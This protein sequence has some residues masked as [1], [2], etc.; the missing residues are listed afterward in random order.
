MY[1]VLL[2]AG[3]RTSVLELAV[4]VAT[5]AGRTVVV[6]AVDVLLAAVDVGVLLL[7]R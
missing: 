4:A 2:A 7:G 6:M 3:H 5:A 1:S